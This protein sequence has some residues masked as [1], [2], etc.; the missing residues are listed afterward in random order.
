[1]RKIKCIPSRSGLFRSFIVNVIIFALPFYLS[2]FNFSPGLRYTHVFQK[3]S[4]NRTY[5]ESKSSDVYYIRMQNRASKCKSQQSNMS[6]TVKAVELYER[7]VGPL[8]SVATHFALIF[9]G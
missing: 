8:G 6:E 3:L 2:M 9:N 7:F 1:M 5:P 4:N